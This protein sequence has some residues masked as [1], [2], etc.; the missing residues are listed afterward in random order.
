[1]DE[2]TETQ[3][4]LEDSTEVEDV[5]KQLG[6]ISLTGSLDASLERYLKTLDEYDRAMKE[7]SKQLSSGYMSLAEANFHNPSPAIRYG[8]DCYDQR[9]QAS[10][11]VLISEESLGHGRHGRLVVSISTETRDGARS[12]DDNP[13]EGH[14]HQEGK[15][16]SPEEPP[17][18]NTQP[19]KDAA[20]EQ[21]SPPETTASRDPLRWFGILVPP[22]LRTAQATFIAALQDPIAHLATVTR[23][24]RSQETEIGRL[25]KQIKKL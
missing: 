15:A 12:K 10:R 20:T 18:T 11:K 21:D 17:E 7:V 5:Q 3:Q 22:A 1:M 19:A 24:L 23:D 13:S 4:T 16:V 8:Q 14:L 25:R 6:K 2:A 9:M